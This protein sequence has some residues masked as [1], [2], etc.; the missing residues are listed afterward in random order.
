MLSPGKTPLGS[1]QPVHTPGPTRPPCMGERPVLSFM[2][3]LAASSPVPSSQSRP[4]LVLKA[5]EGLGNGDRSLE[6][7]CPDVE[8]ALGMAT[9][10]V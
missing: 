6:P 3:V 9:V 4:A 2:H 10:R 1:T 7:F 8:K 5:R